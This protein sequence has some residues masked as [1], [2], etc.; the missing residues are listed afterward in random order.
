MGASEA[1]MKVGGD[2]MK[3]VKLAAALVLLCMLIVSAAPGALAE[4][5]GDLET[6][7][8]EALHKQEGE[9][10][11]D[12]A[13]ELYKTLIAEGEKTESIVLSARM[14]LADIFEKQGRTDDALALY[15]L[16][17]DKAPGSP[18]A[19]TSGQTTPDNGCRRVR[20][21]QRD[22]EAPPGQAAAGSRRA[23]DAVSGFSQLPAKRGGHKYRA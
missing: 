22:I 1:G 18:E 20:P 3:I 21:P 7:Y 16:I 8:Q 2:A 12:A 15:G 10:D 11:V 4:T 14:K 19:A 9:G 17:V 23:E 6:L 5:G 13:A